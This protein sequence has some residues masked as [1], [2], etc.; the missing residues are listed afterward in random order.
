[1]T[2]EPTESDDSRARARAEEKE[3]FLRVLARTRNVS[4]GAREIQRDRTTLYDWRERDAEFRERWD[5]TLRIRE[6]DVDSLEASV[7]ERAENGWLEPVYHNG[8]PVGTVRKFSPT[9]S[10]EVLRVHRKKYRKEEID[11]PQSDRD[12]ANR[13]QEVLAQ[14]RGVT[15]TS[16]KPEDDGHEGNGH[17]GNGRAE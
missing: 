8:R 11:T 14:M 3:T 9:L 6:V 4:A 1:M 2:T 15:E 16:P 13:I 7:F 5:D 12:R 17:A 10:L